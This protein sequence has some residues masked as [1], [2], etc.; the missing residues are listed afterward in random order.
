MRIIDFHMRIINFQ[1][2]NL[3]KAIT[4]SPPPPTGGA[5]GT[6]YHGAGGGE[7]ISVLYGRVVFYMFVWG[8]Y[9][10]QTAKV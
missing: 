3:W 8:F 7:D 5:G 1:L 9:T 4:N 2:E 10:A 6:H